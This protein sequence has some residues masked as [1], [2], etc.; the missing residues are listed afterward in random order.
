MT[1][2][3]RITPRDPLIVRDGR[4][5]N[6][7]QTKM[8]PLGWPY[9][10]LLAGSLRTLLGKALGEYKPAELRE[11]RVRG[12]LPVRDGQLYLP[13]PKDLIVN[14]DNNLPLAARPDRQTGP[15]TNLPLKS[16]RPCLLPPQVE[17]GFKAKKAPQFLSL[18][19]SV[20]WLLE[21]AMQSSE[22]PGFDNPKHDERTHV[23]INPD[24][25]AH[26]DHRLFSTVGLALKEGDE[27]VA[28]VDCDG[29]YS[30]TLSTGWRALHPMGGERRLAHWRESAEASTLWQCP[31][32]IR[33]ALADNPVR[34]RMMLAT[35]AV[36]AA[37]G[38]IPDWV[39]QGEPLPGTNVKF[40]LVGA[41]LDRWK[42]IS[43]WCM[44]EGNEGPKP[45]RWMV[46][47]GAV[48]FLECSSG[49]SAELADHWLKPVSDSAKNESQ[50]SKDGFGLATWGTWSEHN[51]K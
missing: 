18:S 1:H 5:F 38:W 8:R 32:A 14:P 36:W 45:V 28:A 48:Y 16:L 30:K 51:G 11:I 41:C 31:P 22:T 49:N 4:P 10:Q 17:D 39:A 9:P 29:S 27:M 2:Y 26:I 15:A 7:G 13:T 44:E 46:P 43:G 6:F 37:G 40:T 42:P 21:R 20:D 50:E 33:A 23:A 35:P 25:Y 19:Q 34:I 3:L 24:T 47:A 12:P